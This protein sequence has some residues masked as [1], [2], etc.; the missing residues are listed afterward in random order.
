MLIYKIPLSIYKTIFRKR[1]QV[2]RHCHTMKRLHSTLLANVAINV[3]A[4]CNDAWNVAEVVGSISTFVTLRE[5][6]HATPAKPVT[7]RNS[8]V[9]C[10]VACNV[11][12][13]DSAF[14]VSV[15]HF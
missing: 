6:L 10:N 1:I 15:E 11:S 2:L 9:A 13:C 4:I 8:T 7:R 5:T 3:T 12:S 14:N